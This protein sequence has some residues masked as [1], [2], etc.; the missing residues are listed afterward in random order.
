[1]ERFEDLLELFYNEDIENVKGI[2][3]EINSWNGDLD[4]LEV[5]ENDEDFFNTFFAN[6]PAEAVRAS[7]YG[8]YNWADDY[9]RFNA[10]GNIESCTD[11]E[12]QDEIKSNMQEI[13]E[14]II[15]NHEDIN[16]DFYLSSEF[17]E[18]L[19]NYINVEEVQSC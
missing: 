5:Y 4:Y 10:Y 13:L 18:A 17:C 19:E 1:M 9:V 8:D 11:W 12:Y 2:V 6:N 14:K 7:F 15:D 16:I 3:S